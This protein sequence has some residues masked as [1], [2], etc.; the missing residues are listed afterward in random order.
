MTV[1]TLDG[2]GNVKTSRD[3]DV[4]VGEKNGSDAAV[5]GVK[6]GETVKLADEGDSADGDSTA[7]EASVATADGR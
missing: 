5:T 4:K 1:V 2:E 7:G 3:V 6:E